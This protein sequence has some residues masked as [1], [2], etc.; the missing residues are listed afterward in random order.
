MSWHYITEE[1][2]DKELDKAFTEQER[3]QSMR[4]CTCGGEKSSGTHSSWCD[5]N[6][7]APA[8]FRMPEKL[9]F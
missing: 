4:K 2:F 8:P 5:I 1:E 6:P 7:N 9:S 3:Q